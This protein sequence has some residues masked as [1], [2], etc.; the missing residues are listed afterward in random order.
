MNR[1]VI[2]T[3]LL[4]FGVILPLAMITAWLTTPPPAP[5]TPPAP[6]LFPKL[7]L[8]KVPLP[9]GDDPES[10]VLRHAILNGERIYQRLCHHCHGRLGKGDNN[11]YMA[12]IGRKPA[13]HSDLA[14]MQKLSDEEFFVALRDGVKDERGWLTM[15]PWASVLTGQEMRDV[16]VYVRH[17]PLAASPN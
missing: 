5:S 11:D 3:S 13:D 8:P 6:V 10:I 14:A 12:S 15:P 17:L 16:I 4:I 2:Y 1:Y 9:T 7:Q